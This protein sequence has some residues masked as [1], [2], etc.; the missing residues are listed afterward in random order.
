MAG[1]ALSRHRQQLSLV[2][3]V[4]DTING[5]GDGKL[6]MSILR[7]VV[8]FFQIVLCVYSINSSA[9][10]VMCGYFIRQNMNELAHSSMVHY[11]IIKLKVL[12][13][14]T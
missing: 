12:A 14:D 1:V 9:F 2:F 5:T 4:D 13:A 3:S 7:S 10:K 6:I 8:S 11:N